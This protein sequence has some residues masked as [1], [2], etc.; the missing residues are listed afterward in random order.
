MPLQ[1]S[2]FIALQRDGRHCKV[3]VGAKAEGMGFGVYE[4]RSE[5]QHNGL[6][7]LCNDGVN[8]ERVNVYD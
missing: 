2:H 7:K 4:E 6:S 5:Q 1:R 3:S 8:E